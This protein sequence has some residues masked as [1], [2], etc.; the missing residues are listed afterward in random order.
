MKTWIALL[1]GINVGGH[2]KVPMKRLVDLMQA[3]GFTDVRTY[4][5]SGNIVFKGPARPGARIADLIE[6]EFGFRPAVL[7]FDASEFRRALDNNPYD[8][9]VGNTVHIFFCDK[10]PKSVN[11]E[12]L[13]SLR[14]SSEHYTLTGKVFY[15][16]APDGIARSD[17]VT[18]MGKAFPGIT[19]T[20]RNLNTVRR[21]ADMLG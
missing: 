20:A 6:A 14:A 1:R 4:I 18:K 5:Q 15:L 19:M 21:L 17:L 7:N 10:V 3:N 11:F 8:V 9:D 12:R 16:H 2:H 13:E